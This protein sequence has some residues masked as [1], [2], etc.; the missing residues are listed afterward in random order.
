[1]IPFVISEAHPDYKRPYLMQDFGVVKEEEMSK[2]FLDRVC[3]FILDRKPIEDIDHSTNVEMF[4][5]NY[6]DEYYMGNS[7]WDVMI[8]RNNEWENANP[9]YE[10]IFEHIQFLKKE[11]ENYKEEDVSSDEKKYSLLE[12]LENPD[13]IDEIISK[14][15][16][17]FEELLKEDPIPLDFVDEFTYMDKI[18]R[19]LYLFNRPTTVTCNTYK[20]NKQLITRFMDLHLKCLQR[21]IEYGTNLLQDEYSDEVSE[22]SQET[23]RQYCNFILLKKTLDL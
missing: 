21:D 10:S 16:D 8:F 1:M 19:M 6:Y 14:M 15:S 7:P 9:S 13:K 18:E 3:E 23:M 4:F 5:R 22:K 20:E 12:W 17:F 2:Y 11:E